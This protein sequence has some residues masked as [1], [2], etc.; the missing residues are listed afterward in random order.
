MRQRIFRA[1]VTVTPLAV[2]AGSTER[3]FTVTA[4]GFTGS[5]SFPLSLKVLAVSA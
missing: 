1:L 4:A 3:S 2:P 5:Q